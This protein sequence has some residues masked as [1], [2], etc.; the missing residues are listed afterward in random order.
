MLGRGS[1]TQYIIYMCVRVC[2]V[3]GGRRGGH[4]WVG[5]G[6]GGDSWKL[7]ATFPPPL[8]LPSLTPTPFNSVSTSSST[9]IQSRATLGLRCALRFSKSQTKLNHVEAH[10]LHAMCNPARIL[11]TA[12]D[13]SSTNVILSLSL[14]SIL[15]SAPEVEALM[16]VLVKGS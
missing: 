9:A 10:R 5:D 13:A 14:T 11:P 12:A 3:C 6:W 8:L 16:E 1:P 4:V 15:C 2:C 7:F